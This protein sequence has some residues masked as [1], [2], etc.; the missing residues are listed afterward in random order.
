MP[1][2]FTQISQ[3]FKD[4]IRSINSRIEL[5]EGTFTRDIVIDPVAKEF[6]NLYSRLEQV[7]LE[8]SISTASD[9]GLDIIAGNFS[10]VR[11]AARRA[12]G[13][14]TFFKNVAPTTDIVIPSGTLVS[15]ILTDTIPAVLFRTTQNIT[16]RA[17]LAVSYFNTIT[18]KYEIQV[19]VEAVNGGDSG[20]VG[21]GTIATITQAVSGI[22]GVYNSFTT[23]G[24]FNTETGSQLQARLS[25]VLSGL[26]LGTVGGL[27]D[28]VSTQDNVEDVL[29][30]SHGQTGRNDIG[31]VDVYVKGKTFRSFTDE[32]ISISNPYPDFVFTKQPI[33]PTANIS[34]SS[35]VSGVLVPSS[36]QIIKDSGVFGGSTI[37]QDTLHW[38]TAIGP[39]SGSVIAAYQYNGLI[40]DL[41]SALSNQNKNLVNSDTLIK[42]ATE[43]PI[44]VTL[45]IRLLSGN[46]SD[47][48]IPLVTIA[49]DNFLNSLGIGEEIQQSDVINVV[50][51]VSGIDEILIPLTKF[52]SSDGL[53]T[54]NAFNNLTIPQTSYASAGTIT[55]NLF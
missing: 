40:E 30:I 34:I 3:A 10:I 22:D 2:N 53:I 31:S 27:S 29:V 43:I 28:F 16:M 1:R 20:N 13:L 45:S 47:D 25:T 54:E 4:Y 41:Q 7:S 51:Q 55:V 36:F 35:S 21:A 11:K 48:V 26:A 32:F 23:T 38:L 24:G 18:N 37:G 17:A 15:T 12:R 9:V 33:I 50:L 14:V 5:S 39:S 52:Q 42:W 49:I 46:S 8:Q 44:D 19:E 6:E